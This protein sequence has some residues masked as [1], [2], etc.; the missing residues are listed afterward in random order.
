[1]STD[2]H[3]GVIHILNARERS[4]FSSL[5]CMCGSCARDL[6]STCTCDTAEDTRE[7]LRKKIEAGETNDQII[8]EYAQKWGSDA[9]AV[10]PN[11]GGM[12]A[13]YAGPRVAIA[14]G[15]AGM[16][17]L[18]RRWSG[19]GRGTTPKSSA[20][21]GGETAKRDDYDDRL[22]EELRDLDG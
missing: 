12:R 6:L 14:A 4:L 7:A 18:V 9:L 20:R 5:R 21:R 1:M 10:P 11:K 15:G 2:Q 22:D 13:I 19:S 3:D 17:V 16:V 8:M